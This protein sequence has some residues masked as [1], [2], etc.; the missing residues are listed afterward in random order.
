MAIHKNNKYKE[1]QPKIPF[2]NKKTSKIA[3]SQITRP[4]GIITRTITLLDWLQFSYSQCLLSS[5]DFIVCGVA[6]RHSEQFT[7]SF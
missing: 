6:S 4:Y 5:H 7:R 2:Y 3:L 1:L